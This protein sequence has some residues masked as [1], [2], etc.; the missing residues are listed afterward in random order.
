MGSAPAAPRVQ[1]SRSLLSHVA[2]T[3]GDRWVFPPRQAGQRRL[4]KPRRRS[5]SR[6]TIL[7]TVRFAAA[8]LVIELGQA[9][10][11]LSP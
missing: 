7:Q 1:R 3:I 6:R 11:G 8:L 5:A 2:C 4:Q 9:P 10:L